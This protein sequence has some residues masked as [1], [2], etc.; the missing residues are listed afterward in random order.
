MSQNHA[1][2]TLQALEA[3]YTYSCPLLPLDLRRPPQRCKVLEDQ[4]V[5]RA[6]GVFLQVILVVRCLL[7]NPTNADRIT[8][9]ERRLRSLPTDLETYFRYMLETIE[10]AYTQQAVKNLHIALQ[11]AKSLSPMT[12]A[13]LDESEKNSEC[14]IELPAQ[15]M[16]TMDID[17][18]CHDMKL[19]INARCKDLLQVTRKGSHK[20][21][22]A[23]T[24]DLLDLSGL[25]SRSQRF[26]QAFRRSNP[27][28]RATLCPQTTSFI[29][30]RGAR[31]N[32]RRT[33]AA[34]YPV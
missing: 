30:N 17:S 9:L 18:R 27:T 8:D 6:Q 20:F 19:R 12:Y 25:E 5:R 34:E 3:V 23:N 1:S 22:D 28:I 4:I 15:Q 13:M 31:L 32:C 2:N 7:D 33:R 29:S 14:A 10:D 24:M 16:A 21:C 11:A 26:F